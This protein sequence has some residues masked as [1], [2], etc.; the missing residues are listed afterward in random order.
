MTTKH[1]IILFFSIAL[2]IGCSNESDKKVITKI[3]FGS[4]TFQW[5][6]QPIWNTITNAEPDL[7]L[8]IGDAIYGNWDGEKV[9][10][11]TLEELK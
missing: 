3:A 11:V 6:E 10:D 7:F 8:F 1:I 4:C 2:I 5:D 9:Y